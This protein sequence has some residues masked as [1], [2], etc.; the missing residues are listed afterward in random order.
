[1]QLNTNT[2][3]FPD[4]LVVVSGSEVDSSVLDISVAD[5][6]EVVST[7]V[8]VVVGASVDSTVVVSTI[9]EVVVEASVV[10]SSEVVSTIVEVVVGTSSV[11]L[12]LSVVDISVV[13]SVVVVVQKAHPPLIGRSQTCFKGLN[14]N[15]IGHSN[16]N[17]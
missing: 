4:P 14:S 17:H 12:V 13:A 8:D 2:L 1:M 10:A 3:T 7:M 5:S 9:V 11:V 16:K 6:V 15:P